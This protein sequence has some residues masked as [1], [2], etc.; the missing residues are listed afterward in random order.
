MKRYMLWWLVMWLSPAWGLGQLNPEQLQA[1]QARGVPVIDIRTPGEWR[2]TGTIAGAHRLMFFDEMGRADVKGWLQAF[3]RIVPDTGQPFIL[4]C[5][6]GN[7]TTQVGN[8]LEK[9]LGMKQVYHLAPGMK[10]WLREGRPVEFS[11]GSTARLH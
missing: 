5:R 6:S 1:M 4:V 7:R 10:G 8:F 11:A 9:R 2:E 3:H